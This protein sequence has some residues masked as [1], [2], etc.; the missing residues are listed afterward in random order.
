[1]QDKVLPELRQQLAE[2]R[3]IFKGK[4]RKVLTEQIKKTE[5]QISK[6]IDEM[7]NVLKDEG[8]PD[9]MAFMKTYREMENV[10]ERYER[11]VW[12]Y[13]QKLKQKQ[14]P[15]ERPPERKSVREQLRQIQAEG[16]QQARNRKTFDGERYL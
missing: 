8:Y 6:G 12:E 3:G 2:T 5:A 9:V 16:K 15:A 1:M 10:V 4:E 14:R 11:E 13:E 7:P